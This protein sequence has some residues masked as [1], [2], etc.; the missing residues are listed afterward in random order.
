MSGPIST[1]YF[2]DTT[3][4]EPCPRRG[5]LMCTIAT[6]EH[7]H[8]AIS[9]DAAGTPESTDPTMRA[10]VPAHLTSR[11]ASGSELIAAE[12]RRQ[13]PHADDAAARPVVVTAE[14][15]AAIA[16]AVRRNCTL[17][18]DVIYPPRANSDE[19]VYAVAAWI[20][21]PPE[22]VTFGATPADVED[23]PD[24]VTMLDRHAR[25]L[26]V[27]NGAPIP[28]GEVRARHAAAILRGDRG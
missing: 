19:I 16:A 27:L 14:H 25:A 21:D 12:R 23:Q 2:R 5:D 10:N 24:L 26:A 11:P 9:L 13:V 22:W 3:T 1:P 6:R 17:P 28:M 7:L 20:A 8:R 4:G 18:T 15:R